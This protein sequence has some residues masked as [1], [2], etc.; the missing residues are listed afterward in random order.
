MQ[1][2]AR[3]FIVDFDDTLIDTTKVQSSIEQNLQKLTGDPSHIEN[4]WATYQEVKTEKGYVDYREISTRLGEKLDLQPKEVLKVFYQSSF[5]DHLFPKAT[6]L[7]EYLQTLGKV[8]L[9]S[10]GEIELQ[11]HKIKYSG[12]ETLIGKENISIIENKVEKV[13]EIIQ[14]LKNQ[15]IQSLTFID[16]RAD[17]LDQAYKIDKSVSCIWIRGG[18]HKDKLPKTSCVSF[19]SD[20]LDEI[21]DYIY[22][23]NLI[24]EIHTPHPSFNSLKINFGITPNQIRQLI[25]FTHQDQQVQ[26]FTSDMERFINKESFNLWLKNH[27]YI[28]TLVDLHNNLLGIIWFREKDLPVLEYTI[29]DLTKYHITWS[30]RIYE[31]ARGKGLSKQFMNTAFIHYQHSPEYK[32]IKNNGFWSVISCTNLSSIKLHESFGF[33]PVT[34][35]ESNDK[36]VMVLR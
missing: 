17:I 25:T 11:S 9:F 14:Y 35:R 7:I 30:I 24:S 8:I 16:D 27:R 31:N 1:I 34:N 19:Q 20:S 36:M 29:K 3:A 15:G 18:K 5:K 33:V 10:Q 28:Y 21:F 6:Q 26:Q 2:P 12:I 32:S 23:S 13:G 22:N 4:L